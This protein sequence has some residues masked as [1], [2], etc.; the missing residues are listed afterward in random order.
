MVVLIAAALGVMQAAA[1]SLTI[2]FE[3]LPD[4]RPTSQ[5]IITNEFLDRFGV[6]FPDG[7]EVV[8]CR[9][10]PP[11]GVP[12]VEAHSGDRAI[13]PLLEQTEFTYKPFDIRF[14]SPVSAASLY[15]TH[16]V[17]YDEGR[18][19]DVELQAFDSSGRQVGRDTASFT[20][21]GSWHRLEVDAGEAAIV[22][23]LISGGATIYS[24]DGNF[25]AIDDLQFELPAAPTP[26]PPDN[27]PPTVTFLAP[28]EGAAFDDNIVDLQ[29]RAEDNRQLDRVTLGV[30]HDE[31]GTEII[32]FSEANICGSVSYGACLNNPYE[33][34][35]DVPLD[36][37]LEG[38]YTATVEACDTAGL[39][40]QDTVSF[41][42]GL[43]V[44]LW[45]MG[46]EY[47]Q[48]VQDFI[49]TDLDRAP[50][51]EGLITLAD[52]AFGMPVIPGKPLAVRVYVGV[53][54]GPGS[55]SAPS[56][57]F[58]A[59][60][61]LE[62]IL[63]DGTAQV[64]APVDNPNCREQ[65]G[66]TT[67]QA[68][69]PTIHVH[70][71]LGRVVTRQDPAIIT[72]TGPLLVDLELP[73]RTEYDLDLLDQRSHWEG[74]LNFVVPGD[75]TL[76][77]R[78]D[79]LTLRAVVEPVGRAEATDGDN[80]FELQLGRVTPPNALLLRLVRVSLPLQAAP[81]YDEAVLTLRKTLPLM[82]Y[83]ELEVVSSRPYSYDGS[84]LTIRVEFLGL[85]EVTE[86]RL[87]QCTTLWLDLYQA[88]GATESSTLYA[89]TPTGVDLQGCGGYGYRVPGDGG[90]ALAEMP[91]G[92]DDTSQIATIAQ[93][94]YHAHLD[95]R[96]VSNDHE[97]ADGCL[98][99]ESVIAEL[100]EAFTGYNTDCWEPAPHFHAAI[101]EYPVVGDLI[102]ADRGAMGVEFDFA[103]G[104]YLLT[105]Y[106]PCPTGGV[107]RGDELA[108][109]AWIGRRWDYDLGFADRRNP[110]LFNLGYLCREHAN[111]PHD[112]MSYGGNRWTS[113]AQFLGE[114]EIPA[115]LSRPVLA[116]TIAETIIV[117]GRPGRT[118]I[119]RQPAE[120]RLQ[121]SGIMT[122]AG[123]GFAPIF[124]AAPEAVAVSGPTD[125]PLR[126]DVVDQDGEHLELPLAVAISPPHPTSYVFYA[127]TLPPG[128][129]PQRL[130]LRLGDRDLTQV[131]ASSAAPEV[132]LLTPNGG[133]GW[134]QGEVQTISWEASDADGDPL[135]LRVEYS[136][137]AGTTWQSIGISHEDNNIS[138][139][140]DDLPP[141][142]V[143]M[144]RV[145]ASDGM[146][147]AEDTSDDTFCVGVTQGCAPLSVG[148]RSPS[149]AVPLIIAAALGGV[150]G[151]AGLA[152][153]VVLLLRRGRRPA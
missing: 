71:S 149:L 51:E 16:S 75:L 93:E 152:L 30:A 19:I 8:G 63:G 86:E 94:L 134:G 114:T 129:I 5:G 82:P 54:Q 123:A 80:E 136:P 96:H 14:D 120:T 60:G 10:N 102:Y 131:E 81:S 53:R 27:Q 32:P 95:R 103:G 138:V 90:L 116:P 64:L 72:N 88:F 6:R 73:T 135:L 145:V 117:R 65:S 137:D 133:E 147:L 91:T 150:L 7:V 132:S 31:S 21:D 83:D 92:P 101:G 40:A 77:S 79:G 37:R 141:S 69:L 110:D 127:A 62:V 153:I 2:D 1:E 67:G 24:N 85:I 34:T 98:T 111:A 124:P 56:E 108:T 18:T 44:D 74:T 97:E 20:N 78:P 23:L 49:F 144:I 130:T 106:D 61:E 125:S 28:A 12:C 52:S 55:P 41:V 45:V 15:I 113:E 25:L 128:V 11:P 121:V 42:L 68:C 115:E 100:I 47:N 107:D 59:T 22:R 57:G 17:Q 76:L 143:A 58:A 142:P 151:L 33:N 112:F 70:P 146:R 84:R 13:Q 148:E 3:R 38:R 39:C 126:L 139:A 9:A 99:G 26:L 118:M 46:I 109:L 140:V 48:A 104:D 36:P 50:G 119:L 35:R 29:F 89:L 87:S 122:A 4:G 43:P 105:L 66:A